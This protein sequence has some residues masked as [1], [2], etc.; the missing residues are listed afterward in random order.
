M[1]ENASSNS[2]DQK[3]TN[4]FEK[5]YLSIEVTKQ[6]LTENIKSSTTSLSS[7]SSNNI[8]IT[9]SNTFHSLLI[10]CIIPY[11]SP[12]DLINFKLCNK[13]VNSLINSKAIIQSVIS[14][15]TKSFNS[16]EIRYNIW[17]H[18]LQI[19]KYKKEIYKGKQF[20]NENNKDEEY[21]NELIKKVDLIK[22]KDEIIKK[23][24]TE[25]QLKFVLDSLDYVQRDVDRTFYL[26]YFTK[27]NGKK[28]LK[29][30][31]ETMS[32]IK[33]NIGYCQG[34]NFIVGALIYLFQNEIKAFFAFNCLL[35][36]YE[37]KKL[38]AYNT[39]DYAI[40]VYQLNYYV[41][42]YIPS[43][44]Y[45]FKKED[46]SFDLLYSNWIMTI[47][48][49]Y[50]NMKTLD[51]AWTCFF[52]DKWK[53]LLKI[54]LIIIYD[55]ADELVKCDLVGISNLTKESDLK[56]HKNL[57]RSYDL[58]TRK[59]KIK[60]SELKKLRDEYY[61]NLATEKLEKTK[62]EVDKWD[63]D[64]QE[65]LNNYL[66][67]K[68]KINLN[69][70]K[71]IENYKVMMEE[72]NKKYLISFKKYTNQMKI[73]NKLKSKID[74]LATE[75][76]SYENIFSIYKSAVNDISNK[77]SLK[78]LKSDNTIISKNSKEKKEEE[79]KKEIIEK[80]K[81]KI[82]EKY[83][84]IVSEYEKESNLLY[85][86]Y[87]IIDKYKSE[88]DRIKNEKVK[89]QEQMNDYFFLCEKKEQEL[90]KVLVEKL[91]LSNNF[92]KNNK[93]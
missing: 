76:L 49:N 59:F 31:L 57:K 65:C 79:Y 62:K 48:S 56:Y 67:E 36:S 24:Y 46:L 7:V 63:E 20:I 33:E 78:E 84:P 25:T 17:S 38:F 32:I 10:Y 72:I 26:D 74:V 44:Y 83:L 39:P 15:S 41:K 28:E 19:E 87:D 75:K 88:I 54:C 69:T 40:R 81:N 5:Y 77:I 29:N 18:Y 93:F 11:L 90:L 42:K 12:K 51:F 35:N 85:R 9:K 82:L 92:I 22:K 60:N 6:K 8:N 45:H 30:V 37:L 53:G 21:Y 3:P 34:M 61:I 71:D 91:K 4:I 68:E 80:E 50:F 55:L 47:F 43:V 64:Q 58:Y 27:G 16:P 23:E 52:I 66:K 89:R 1:S 2:I 86:K 70:K 13:L 73:I 14:Y